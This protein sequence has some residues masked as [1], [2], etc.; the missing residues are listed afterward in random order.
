MSLRIIG[1]DSSEYMCKRFDANC[2][3]LYPNAAG[4][5][6]MANEIKKHIEIKQG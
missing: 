3:Q 2:I 4:Y 1:G 5:L 6:Q